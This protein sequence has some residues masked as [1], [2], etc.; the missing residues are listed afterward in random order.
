MKLGWRHQVASLEYNNVNPV[1]VE[2]VNLLFRWHLSG[3]EAI[4]GSQLAFSIHR[5]KGMVERLLNEEN[6]DLEAVQRR[7]KA[8]E[9]DHNPGMRQ[10]E[11]AYLLNLAARVQ[12]VMRKNHLP[13]AS[14]RRGPYENA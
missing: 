6:G 4:D 8:I 3:I 9:W 5:F 7:I 13:S 2:K 12:T 14:E 1:T 10:P 11:P